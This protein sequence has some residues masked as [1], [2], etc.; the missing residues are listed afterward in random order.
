MAPGPDG[1][2][3]V[4]VTY[5]EYVPG[6]QGNGSILTLIDANGRPRA[7]WPIALPGWWCGDGG[8]YWP[9][10]VMAAD[11]SLRLMCYANANP[12]L[13]WHEWH[14]F[15]FAVDPS[16]RPLNGWPVELPT[17]AAGSQ[18][19]MVGDTLVVRA[20]EVGEWDQAANQFAGVW[21]L[22]SVA[23][24]GSLRAGGRHEVPDTESYGFPR[25]GPDGIAYQLAYSETGTKIR[26]F[27]FNPDGRIL[28]VASGSVPFHTLSTWSGAG[29]GSPA[30]VLA[31]DGTTFLMSD[32][33]RTVYGLDP[34][35]Q[36]MTGWPYRAEPWLQWQG[37]C[38]AD[39]TGC[40]ENLSHAAV[41]PGDV[42]YLP[43]AGRSLVAIGPDGRVRPG[44]PV[45]LKRPGAE[46]WSVVVGSDGT[47]YA[48]AIEPEAGGWSSA[49]ILAIALDG[50]V[51]YR[52]TVVEP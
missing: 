16:G 15:A 50:T 43:L 18:M 3:Y 12:D 39:T 47:A 5:P 24:D 48:L 49:T 38:P 20:S 52:A 22:I 37:I 33:E 17:L 1:G 11:G 51:N 42:L 41:G 4:V 34:S 36:V 6:W 30:V 10:P 2:L 27:T 26:T 13:P 44:W 29:P 7:G 19:S 9:S 35:G 28:P 25:L 14:G 31:A 8:W 21:W 45:V 40:G 23:A 46:F 32:D